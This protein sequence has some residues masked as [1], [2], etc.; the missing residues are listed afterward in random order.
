[1]ATLSRIGSSGFAIVPALSLFLPLSHSPSL[2][3]RENEGHE[4]GKAEKA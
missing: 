1:V 3:L 2:S 4:D